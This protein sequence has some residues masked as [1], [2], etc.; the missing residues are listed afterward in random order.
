MNSEKDL[1]VIHIYNLVSAKKNPYST[2]FLWP[3]MH[4]SVV[5]SPTSRHTVMMVVGHD[6]LHP[7]RRN[8]YK[9]SPT[10]TEL[11][12]ALEAVNTLRINL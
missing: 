10:R 11:S 6:S 4:Q 9:L 2:S 12:A 7:I 1:I 3:S 5:P 8:C